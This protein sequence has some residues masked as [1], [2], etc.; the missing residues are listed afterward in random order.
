MSKLQ[1][2]ELAK[3]HGNDWNIYIDSDALV[4]PEMY[5]VTEHLRKDTVCHNGRDMAGIRWRYDQYFRRDGR[6][7]GS[8]NWFAIASDWCLDL[9]R[10][11]DDL[12]PEEA[13]GNINITIAERNSGNCETAHLISDYTLSRNIARFGLKIQTVMDL[14][15]QL[16]W[17]GPGGLPVSPFLFHKYTISNEQKAREMLAILSTP[18][19]QMGPV[20]MGWG[21]LT[22]EG[23]AEYLKKWA[24]RLGKGRPANVQDG[25]AINES[26]NAPGSHIQGWMTVEE[27]NWLLETGKAMESIVEVGSWKGRSTFAQCSS[28]CPRVYAVDHF[29]GS[30]EHQQEFGSR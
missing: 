3:E 2:H 17:R 4:N 11:L 10:P 13:I 7:I 9:W 19:G 5:D 12:T 29:K 21:L 25:T 23:V 22:P 20:G 8:C 27:L 24:S 6:H 18:N 14:C 1:I 30:S 26:T 16:G 15:G 28:G